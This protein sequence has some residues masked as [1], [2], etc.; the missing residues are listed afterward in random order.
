MFMTNVSPDF[1]SYLFILAIFLKSVFSR[2]ICASHVLIVTHKS[3]YI[4]LSAKTTHIVDA[5]SINSCLC[6]LAIWTHEH[7]V[8]LAGL[9]ARRDRKCEVVTC[10]QLSF[11]SLHKRVSSSSP[12]AWHRAEYGGTGRRGVLGRRRTQAPAAR[13]ERFSG[14]GGDYRA[15]RTAAGSSRCCLR[16]GS[17]PRL[18][19]RV[20]RGDLLRSS[21]PAFRGHR[22]F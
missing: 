19:R 5:Q 6:S 9:A 2:K 1:T 11:Q 17:R 10:P 21:H 3:L 8:F 7:A 13:R 22:A 18:C 4:L 20:K 14:H 15:P 12:R 16:R